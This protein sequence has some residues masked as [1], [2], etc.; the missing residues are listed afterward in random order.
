MAVRQRRMFHANNTF[1]ILV[2]QM[3][4]YTAQARHILCIE[5]TLILKISIRFS[6]V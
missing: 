4:L 5:I 3:L 2:M 6:L 1:F